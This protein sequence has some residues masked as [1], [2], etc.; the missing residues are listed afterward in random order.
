MRKLTS[1]KYREH[2]GYIPYEVHTGFQLNPQ[3]STVH[4]QIGDVYWRH[5]FAKV[6][7]DVY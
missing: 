2:L 7:Q 4:W 6:L 5:E 1:Y 3:I